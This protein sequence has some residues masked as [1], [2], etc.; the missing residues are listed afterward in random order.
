[1]INKKKKS[2]GFIILISCL[3]VAKSQA[4]AYGLYKDWSEAPLQQVLR[5]LHKE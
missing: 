5:I 2:L 1:M 4:S 3:A